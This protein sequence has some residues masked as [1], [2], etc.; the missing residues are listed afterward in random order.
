MATFNSGTLATKEKEMA[1]NEGNWIDSKAANKSAYKL[2]PIS[3]NS[4]E[5]EQNN[6][7]DATDPDGL[8]EE[9]MVIH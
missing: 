5:I 1:S 3:S 4:T 9:S 7:R 6:K 2:K 8:A